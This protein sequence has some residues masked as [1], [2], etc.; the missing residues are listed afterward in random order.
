MQT[1]CLWR[2][3][4]TITGRAR[5]AAFFARKME[6]CTGRKCCFTT[7]TPAQLTWRS[8]R[9]IRRRFTPRCGRRAVPRGAFTHPRTAQEAGCIARMT[10]EITDN[11][12]TGKDWPRMDWGGWELRLRPAMPSGCISLG[13]PDRAGYNGRTMAESLG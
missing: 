2:G 12:R 13:A 8:I 11:R 3:W 5:S 10:A 7:K 4:G 1:A 9:A 6:A